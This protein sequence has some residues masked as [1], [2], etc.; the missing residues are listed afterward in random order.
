MEQIIIHELTRINY[1]RIDT[2]ETQMDTNKLST[3]GTNGTQKDTIISE[4]SDYYGFFRL[5]ERRKHICINFVQS[6]KRHEVGI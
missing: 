1:P 5:A 4:N 3:N 2:N 6:E